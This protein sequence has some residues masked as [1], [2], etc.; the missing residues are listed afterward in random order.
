VHIN[1][2]TIFYWLYMVSIWAAVILLL[3]HEADVKEVHLSIL[4]IYTLSLITLIHHCE[5]WVS[6]DTFL[7]VWINAECMHAS[8]QLH[9][10][11]FILLELLVYVPLSISSTIMIAASTSLMVLEILHTLKECFF[12]GDPHNA[13][14][15]TFIKGKS[16]MSSSSTSG[17]SIWTAVIFRIPPPHIFN[18]CTQKHHMDI[19][20]V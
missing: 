8:I 4:Y 11:H 1:Y 12:S 19:Y 20:L 3:E 6:V 15:T 5:Y 13:R 10:L 2:L 7:K 18:L 16:N 9:K 17:T 14:C